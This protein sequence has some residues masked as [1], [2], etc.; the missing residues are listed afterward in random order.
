M[1]I[2]NLLLGR[3]ALLAPHLLQLFGDAN[4]LCVTGLLIR[5]AGILV[6]DRLPV[7]V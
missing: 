7:I 1:L 4:S 6:T 5:R 3:L 2:F